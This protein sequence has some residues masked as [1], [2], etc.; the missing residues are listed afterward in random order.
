MSK[1]K[2]NELFEEINKKSGISEVIINNLDNIYVEKDG[3]LIRID[4]KFT[5]EDVEEFCQDLA[6]HNRKMFNPDNPIMDGNLPDGSR[7]NLI[8]KDYTQGCHAVTIRR[9]MKSIKTFDAS[10]GIF[11]LTPNWMFFL[12]T[13]VKARVNIVV[14]GGTGVGKTTFLNLL[15]Q[16]IPQKERIITIED[17]RELQF[18]L[19]NVVRLEA[20]P[21]VGAQAG[22]AIRELLKNTLRM[23]PDR[24]IV[25]EC[26]G[27][28]VFDLLQAMNTGHEGSMTSVHANSPGEC[29]LRLENLYML[30]GYDLPIKALRYQISTA[31]DY[32]I[33]IRRDKDGKRLVSHVTEISNMEGDKI[34]MQDVGT[35]KN[36]E[37]KF[38]GLVPSKFEKL[39]KAGLPK[40]FFIG[41]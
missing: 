40:D 15:L 25:G 39:Q 20:R 27:G 41:T 18:N 38:T 9:Y 22:L 34:L 35:L 32:I 5:N 11:G 8:H 23:R 33:Q 14:S 31:V 30:S 17:T 16:E 28:E 1:N 36:G 2:V 21:A 4:V 24:I 37:F 6:N 7:V 10:P 26:R 13:L 3:E 12:K 29:L 19:P